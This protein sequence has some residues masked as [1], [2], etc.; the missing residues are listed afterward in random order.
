MAPPKA[1]DGA[2][3]SLS[4]HQQPQSAP[5]R[6]LKSR[7]GPD[8]GQDSHSPILPGAW[9]G[10]RRAQ[11]LPRRPNCL[12]ARVLSANQVGPN[13]FALEAFQ[14]ARSVGRQAQPQPVWPQCLVARAPSANQVG[15][16]SFALEALQPARSLE[17][18]SELRAPDSYLGIV[19]A[20]SIPA[21]WHLGAYP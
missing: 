3:R 20:A 14:S 10:K 13:S 2:C 12:V 9:D 7:V 6:H 18:T 11:P 17:A 5:P 16:N 1:H 15:P 21:G 4:A 8:G 19:P